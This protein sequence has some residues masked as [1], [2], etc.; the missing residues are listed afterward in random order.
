M[1]KV[2]E[3][4]KEGYMFDDQAHAHTLSG[5]PLMG[6]TTLI[7]E[8]MPPMLSWYGSGMAC[9]TLGWFDRKKGKANYLPDEIGKPKLL[10]CLNQIKAM[11]DDQY[12]DLL[13]TAYNAHNAYKKARGEAGTDTHA[14][15]E[16]AIKTAIELGKGYLLEPSAYADAD[17]KKFAEWGQDK[18]FLYSEVYVYSELLWLGGIIDFVYE[19]GK[20]T[21]IGDVK[22]SKDIYASAI[23]QEG[24]YDCQQQENGYYDKDGNKIGDPLDIQG[25]TVV[26][27]PP[28]KDLKVCTYRGTQQMREFGPS[29]VQLYKTLQELK[30]I[31]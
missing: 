27:I 17:V 4:V 5:K 18:K 9:K 13:D 15:I 14:L 2:I 26:N 11:T 19:D 1:N 3:K 16:E 25:Y 29:L 28:E 31:L 6:T 22:T 10:E 30:G 20:E 8:V 23:I 21:L 7:K 24:L 12:L